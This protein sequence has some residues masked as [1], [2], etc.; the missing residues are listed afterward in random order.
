MF[1]LSFPVLKHSQK[2]QM[3]SLEELLI[4]PDVSFRVSEEISTWISPENKLFEF[5]RPHELQSNSYCIY[6]EWLKKHLRQSRSAPKLKKEQ[7]KFATSLKADVCMCK[8]LYVCNL[9]WRNWNLWEECT[10]STS[11]THIQAKNTL[12]SGRTYHPNQKYLGVIRS[13]DCKQDCVPKKQACLYKASVI[14]H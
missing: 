13:F 9:C 11:Q 6:K 10:V 12:R 4:S 3:R 1:A 7:Y 5:F 14:T 8:K 2:T